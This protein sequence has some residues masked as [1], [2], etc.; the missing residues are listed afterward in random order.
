MGYQKPEEIRRHLAA[1]PASG[2]S[3][4]AYCDKHGIH[5]NTFYHWR[6]RYKDTAGAVIA[7]PFARLQV[8]SL[9]PLQ[10]FEVVFANRTQLRIPPRFEAEALRT[11]IE[12]LG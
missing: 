12:A 2:L 8:S 3:I 1:Q 6:K 9:V 5:H 7:V 10:G 4:A 11:L